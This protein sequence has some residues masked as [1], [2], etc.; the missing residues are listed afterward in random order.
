MKFMVRKVQEEIEAK[1]K[2]VE[3]GLRFIKIE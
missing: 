2:M 3:W 1:A